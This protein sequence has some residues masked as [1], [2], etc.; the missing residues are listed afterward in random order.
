MKANRNPTQRGGGATYE[1]E[2]K[3]G[4]LIAISDIS[5]CVPFRIKI[6]DKV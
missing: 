5:L 1:L 6:V 3:E 2:Q 4:H